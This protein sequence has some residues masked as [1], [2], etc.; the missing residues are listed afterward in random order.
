MG[1]NVLMFKYN[2]VKKYQMCFWF[3][4]L[5][6]N[7]YKCTLNYTKCANILLIFRKMVPN[8]FMGK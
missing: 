8:V 2:F 1:Q 3:S 7:A 6:S 5:F 4:V